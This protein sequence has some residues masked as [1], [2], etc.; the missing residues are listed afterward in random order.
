MSIL[1]EVL[2]QGVTNRTT[3]E[4]RQLR[5]QTAWAHTFTRDGQ[6]H[7]YPERIELFLPDG[8]PPYS[9]GKYTIAPTSFYVGRYG[10]LE[11][12]PRLKRVEKP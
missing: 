1:I 6:A 10:R 2:E 7:R 8:E 4:G 3:K 11:F 9:P 12:I 5:F